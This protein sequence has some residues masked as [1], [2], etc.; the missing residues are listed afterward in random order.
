MSTVATRLARRFADLLDQREYKALG[1]ILSPDC[2]YEFRD[3][4]V[5][6]SAGI[7]EVY[8]KNTEWGFKVFDRI[9]FESEVVAESKDSARVTFTDH[10][11]CK[12]EVHHHKCQQIVSVD[13]S[14]RI[15]HI[16]HVDLDGKGA[17]L[18]A[19]FEKC[20]VARPMQ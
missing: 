10:L 8:R 12:G 18:D 15:S 17:A 13:E 6:G 2:K 19:F 14:K 5:H 3:N 11:Y 16:V 4:T 7:I 1:R 20:G 9:E